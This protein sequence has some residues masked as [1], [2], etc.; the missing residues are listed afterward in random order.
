MYF[1]ELQ[2][3][4]TRN[5]V[6]EQNAEA[7]KNKRNTIMLPS[8]FTRSVR[9]MDDVTPSSA[10]YKIERVIGKD[11]IAQA[12]IKNVP[13]YSFTRS[14]THRTNDARSNSGSRSRS[15]TSRTRGDANN[16]VQLSS[17]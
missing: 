8:N 4:N 14:Q 15:R 12:G 16:Y 5:Y 6:R 1:S 11:A 10:D 9:N 7:L 17:V 13:K 2:D 3:L